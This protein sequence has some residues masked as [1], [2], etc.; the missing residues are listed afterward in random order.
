[1]EVRLKKLCTEILCAEDPARKLGKTVQEYLNT[2]SQEEYLHL[3]NAAYEGNDGIALKAV[4]KDNKITLDGW[5]SGESEHINQQEP[6]ALAPD[7]YEMPTFNDYRS[8]FG[9]FVI[10][11][12]WAEFTPQLGGTAYR[13][14]AN[15]TRIVRFKKSD[16]EYIYQ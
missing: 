10:P 5:R 14:G 2:C 12:A 16:V 7:G 11:T 1:M 15:N 13:S 4:S 8:I 9:A 3:W 6:S